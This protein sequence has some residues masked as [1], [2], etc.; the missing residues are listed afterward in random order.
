MNKFAKSAIVASVISIL[1][2]AISVNYVEK[3]LLIYIIS[4]IC[5]VFSFSIAYF[6]MEKRRG[7]GSEN[8]RLQISPP[9]KNFKNFVYGCMGLL[10]LLIFG[11]IYLFNIKPF[12]GFEAWSILPIGL[13]ISVILIV[14]VQCFNCIAVNFNSN[15]KKEC[16]L[17]CFYTLAILAY[18]VSRYNP[19]IIN[20]DTYDADAYLTSIYNVYFNVPYSI[21]TTGIYGHYA[22]FFKIPM[23][24]FGGDIVSISV[25]VAIVAGI[26]MFAFVYAVDNLIERT[27]LKV[28]V[29][30]AALLEPLYALP[31]SY[32]QTSPS[33]YLFPAII[34]AVI[35]FDMKKNSNKFY[36]GVILS[37]LAFLWNFESGVATAVAWFIYCEIRELQNKN[38][39]NWYTI[40]N[41]FAIPLEL[42]GALGI[43]VIYNLSCGGKPEI[44]AF[45]YPYNHH[46]E[47]FSLQIQWGSFAYIIVIPLFMSAFLWAI[48]NTKL[49]GRTNRYAASVAAMSTIGIALFSYYM[50]RFAMCNVWMIVL[51]LVLLL[52]ML[53]DKSVVHIIEIIKNKS[54]TFYAGI[55]SAMAI[56]GLCILS[57]LALGNIFSGGMQLALYQNGTKDSASMMSWAEEVEA[58]VPDNT[59]A[60]GYGAW[61]LYSMLDWDT[62]YH[63]NDLPNLV[64]R[65]E[66]LEN[67]YSELYEKESIFVAGDLMDINLLMEKGNYEMQNTFAFGNRLYYYLVKRA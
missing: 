26:A 42:L 25:M 30:L 53:V 12:Y 62:G 44:S 35:A 1:S 64:A 51:E 55:K 28:L 49:F 67:F 38:I 50:N 21:E 48:C 54:C 37:S 10:L 5:Y 36:L 20:A 59:Y 66:A 14:S 23:K 19:N 8:H 2:I 32:Y 43:Y 60:A 4:L 11:S 27:L 47:D 58:V 18:A 22:I 39:F 3:N 40:K 9:K 24:I 6:G 46:L 63:I 13:V 41:I 45:F 7:L 17:Y 56:F 65:P 52:G 29:V 31:Y 15:E 33:R 16:Y 61:A 57:A 34:L